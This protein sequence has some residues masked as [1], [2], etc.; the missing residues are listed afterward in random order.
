LYAYASG[1]ISW[2]DS[3]TSSIPINLG[4]SFTTPLVNVT[5][6]YYVE[7]ANDSC[8]SNRIPVYA[9]SVPCDSVTIPNVF[10]PN[11]DGLNDILDFNLFG[12]TCFHMMIYDRWGAEVFATDQMEIGWRGTNLSNEPLPDGV[13]FYVIEYCPAHKP[14]Q[15]KKGFIHLFN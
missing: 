10:T 5:T 12:A 1:V 6:T 15:M 3:P 7:N 2:Y 14:A 9:I 4:N 13:Y 11:G 8:V